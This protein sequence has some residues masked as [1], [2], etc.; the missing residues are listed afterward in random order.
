MEEKDKK[1]L[2]HYL[3]LKLK[4][5]PK[6]KL[7]LKKLNEKLW[8]YHLEKKAFFPYGKRA[9]IKMCCGWVRIFFS[10]FKKPK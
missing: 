10:N 2:K 6:K 5:L 9:Q 7:N 8:L 3:S 4:F 1:S